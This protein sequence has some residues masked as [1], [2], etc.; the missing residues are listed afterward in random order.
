[1]PL[2]SA[3][4]QIL[5]LLTSGENTSALRF[6][7]KPSDCTC[8]C[9]LTYYQRPNTAPS[10]G[11][12]LGGVLTQ[13]ASWRWIFWFLGILSGLC[14]L[15][16]AVCLPET[17]RRIV[18]NGSIPARGISRTLLSC[19]CRRPADAG[20][21][22]TDTALTKP[23]FRF[24]NPITCLR[25]VFHK[26]T[27]LILFANAVFYMTYSCIQAS[28]SPLLMELYGLDTLKVGLTYLAYGI[29]C[30]VASYATGEILVHL[31]FTFLTY[32]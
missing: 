5:L 17:G 11:P 25:I 1:M 3:L 13:R 23:T 14:I 18:G 20:S 32:M 7:G 12:V 27:A 21:S 10:L 28:L 6:A 9:T 19:I 2:P 29:G 26:D 24:P 4:W 16:I 22:G 8:S 15:M 31:L 30:G